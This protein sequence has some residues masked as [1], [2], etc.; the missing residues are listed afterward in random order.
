MNSSDTCHTRPTGACIRTCINALVEIEGAYRIQDRMILRVMM[1]LE[2]EPPRPALA[3]LHT[4]PLEV[5][6]KKRV[7]PNP[8]T[9]AVLR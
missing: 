7:L 9:A 2:T 3:S 6:F 8:I 4:D 5:E 1:R